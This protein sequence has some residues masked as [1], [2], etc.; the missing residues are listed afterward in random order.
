MRFPLFISR[1]LLS[2]CNLFLTLQL[3]NPARKYLLEFCVQLTLS[4]LASLVSVVL[5]LLLSRREMIPL[6]RGE[7]QTLAKRTSND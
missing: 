5:P 4:F 3:D 7:M 2:K 6:S 1:L